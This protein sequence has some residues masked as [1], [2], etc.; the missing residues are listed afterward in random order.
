MSGVASL[1]VTGVDD[2]FVTTNISA[3]YQ[4]AGRKN[5]LSAPSSPVALTVLFIQIS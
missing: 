4:A 5:Q 2:L 1:S 3:L